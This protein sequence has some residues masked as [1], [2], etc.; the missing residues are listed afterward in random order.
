[1]VTYTKESIDTAELYRQYIEVVNSYLDLYDEVGPNRQH[2][3]L[4]LMEIQQFLKQL[5][6]VQLLQLIVVIYIIHYHHL[7]KAFHL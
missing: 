7:L 6:V 4:V 1:M 2:F 3:K 5:Q